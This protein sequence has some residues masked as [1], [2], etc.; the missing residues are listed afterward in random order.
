MGDGAYGEDPHGAILAGSGAL[1]DFG[2]V[3]SALHDAIWEAVPADAEPERLALRRRF[4]LEHVRPGQTVLDLGC[5][6]GEFSAALAEAGATPVAVDVA[7][8]A[9]RR[10]EV[11]VPGLDLRLWRDGEPLPLADA[12]VDAV[13]AGEVIEHVL[14][15]APWL[16]E[17]RR[18]LRPRGTLLLTTPHHGPLTLVGLA[19]SRRRFARHFEPRSDHVR[20]FSPRTLRELLDDLGFDVARLRVRHG[21][22]LARAVRG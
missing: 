1:R 19:L 6:A 4:L 11:R 18:V 17:V 12:S 21:T 13:W 14:D 10:A 8:E 7:R 22:I 3:V 5:G 16:S 15:V 20:F 2:D 9:L